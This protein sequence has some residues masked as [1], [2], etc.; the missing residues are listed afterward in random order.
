[1]IPVFPGP[2]LLAGLRFAN[3]RE[4]LL[5]NRCFVHRR[6]CISP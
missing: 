5:G 2:I 4:R 1:M 3:V 6:S